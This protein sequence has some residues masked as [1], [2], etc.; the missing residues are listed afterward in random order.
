MATD[1]KGDHRLSIASPDYRPSRPSAVPRAFLGAASAVRA[2]G[3]GEAIYAQGSRADRCYLLIS[4][5]AR[6][7]MNTRSG[8]RRIVD[9]IMPGDYFGLTAAARHAFSI[10]A[11]VPDT[12]VASHAMR[13]LERIASYDLEINA[14]IREAAFAT[15]SRL[16]GRILI[17]GQMTAKEKVGSFL[18]AMTTRLTE[19]TADIIIL[20]MSRYDVADYLAISVET[21]SRALTRFKQNGT[22]RIAGAR[23]IEIVDRVGLAGRDDEV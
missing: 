10:E 23:Q 4:G 18:L 3:R 13:H 12:L 15:I 7:F 5:M 20:P 14:I 1:Q 19:R 8:R 11:V 16:Q 22:I 6:K 2:Y 17:L 9:F 21:V